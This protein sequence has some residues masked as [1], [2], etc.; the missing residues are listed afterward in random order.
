MPVIRRV[1]T[2]ELCRHAYAM[3][4]QGE[5]RPRSFCD[6]QHL[7]QFCEVLAEFC[8]VPRRLSFGH[9]GDQLAHALP[10][11]LMGRLPHG[12]KEPQEFR[13]C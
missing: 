6:D 1:R 9:R 5:V 8:A 3:E 7:A 12:R 4:S 2:D 11:A 13:G 10:V